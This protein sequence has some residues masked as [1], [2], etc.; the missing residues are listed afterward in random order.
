MELF[1]IAICLESVVITFVILLGVLMGKKNSM[2]EYFPMLLLMNALTLLSTMGSVVFRNNA[3]M[4][5]LTQAFLVLECSFLFCGIAAFNLYVDTMIGYRTGKKNALL[6]LLPT[7]VAG[8]AIVSWISSLLTGWFFSVSKTGEVTYG[9]F[10]MVMQF[11]GIFMGFFPV[12]RVMVNQIMEKIDNRQAN[13]IYIFVSVPLIS[14]PLA[15]YAKSLGVLLAAMTVS[16][17][18]MYISIHVRGEQAVLEKQAENEKTQ[19]NLVMSQL[20]PHF[21]FNSLTTIKYLTGNNPTLAAEALG[22]FSEY[23][24]KNLDTIDAENLISFKEELEHTKK[25]L[26]LEKLRFGTNLRV[27]YSV[28]TDDFMVP[29]LSLQP[30]VEN[31]VKHGVTRKIG[32][33]TVQIIVRETDRYYKIIVKDDGVGFEQS[34]KTESGE[35]THI[36]I[37][38]VRKRISVIKG[39]TL[40]VTSQV[41][42][43]TTAEYLIMKDI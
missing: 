42:L 11:F 21:L 14:L 33:G 12:I 20:Q 10:F 5:I 4:V 43:G 36:G 18:I 37:G 9:K 38:D 27:Q 29:P 39:S 35:E 1:N 40:T 7:I 3:N 32:G 19:T 8:L 28:D 22:Y 24:R 30:I 41:G 34:N 31:A 23:L 26:W 15:E 17:V 16:Y 2:N 13:A 25:Y 6:R